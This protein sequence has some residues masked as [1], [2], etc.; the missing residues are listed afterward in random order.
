VKEAVVIAREGGDGEKHLVAYYTVKETEDWP[1]G[2]D[3]GGS[4]GEEELRA[5]LLAKLPIYMVPG[6]YVRLESLPLTPNGKLDRKALPSPEGHLYGTSGYEAPQGETEEGLAGIWAEVLK[7][8]RVGRNDN[9]F[10]IGGH[11]LLA[12]R[13]VLRIRQKLEVDFTVSDMFTHPVL[14][15]QA[16]RIIDIQLD[17]FAAPNLA[18]LLGVQVSS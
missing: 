1:Q 14:Q 16:S 17:Q 15:L 4:A 2:K 11:S 3:G 12:A 8:E 6:V 18:Q 9:F 10:E 13:V 7:V 5:H